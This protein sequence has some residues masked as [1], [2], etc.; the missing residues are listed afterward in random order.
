MSNPAVVVYVS[1]EQTSRDRVLLIQNHHYAW[2]WGPHAGELGTSEA[3][4]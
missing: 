2:D 1:V 3:R 4:Y